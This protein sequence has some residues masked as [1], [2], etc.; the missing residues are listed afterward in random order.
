MPDFYRETRQLNASSRQ[1]GATAFLALVALRLGIGFHFCTEGVNKLRDPQPYSARFF[2]AA[3]GPYARYF[4]DLVYDADG[5]ARLAI[6]DEGQPL[7]L[8]NLAQFH[9]Q[10]IRHYGFDESQAAAAA[11]H[12]DQRSI[13]LES[14][15]TDN[16]RE[17]DEYR[18]GLERRKRFER[19]PARTQVS[20]LR[21][22]LDTIRR[23]LRDKQRELIAPIDQL[24]T[25]FE[26]DITALASVEQLKQGRLALAK[27]GR[28]AVD[29]DSID[30]L[31]RYF[32]VAVGGLLIAGLFV[33]LASVVG[34]G[35][36]MLVIATQWPGAEGAISVWPQVIEA[37][38]L[39]VLAG[40]GA[41]R[42]AGLDF[43]LGSLRLWCCPSEY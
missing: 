26:H 14:W 7:A 13:Q 29:S 17:I 32:D 36:L 35:F 1:I 21:G 18:Q 2:A 20:S 6:D 40:T 10:A 28:R 31:V 23:E 16:S 12:L 33:R 25:G 24:L 3:K 27:P 22:Q 11:K 5:L 8:Q 19:D 39:L 37:L 34:A 9:E 41:G 43:I 42:L 38:G 15:L 4:H 30:L